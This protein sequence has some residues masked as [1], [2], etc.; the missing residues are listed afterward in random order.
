M[1][2]QHN[3]RKGFIKRNYDRRNKRFERNKNTQKCPI[4]H[5]SIHEFFTAI[6]YKGSDNP[7][8]FDCILKELKSQEELSPNEKI[9]YLG[10]GSFGII[11]FRNPSSPIKFLIRKRIQYETVETS[12]LWRRK[13]PVRLHMK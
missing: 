11:T 7:A 13:L 2:I 1:A 5:K 3:K 9:C 6:S 8:H 4:C 10:N 12:P